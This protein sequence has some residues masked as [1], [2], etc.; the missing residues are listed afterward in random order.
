M[1]FARDFVG[2]SLEAVAFTHRCNFSPGLPWE[3]SPHGDAKWPLP[4]VLRAVGIAV[5][6]G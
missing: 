1:S 2:D 3:R 5:A 6:R 4:L